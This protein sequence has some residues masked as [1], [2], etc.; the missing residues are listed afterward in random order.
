MVHEFKLPDV[1]DGAEEASVLKWMVEEGDGVREDDPIAEVETERAIIEIPSP[2]SGEVLELHAEERET[3]AVGATLVT[4]DTEEDGEENRDEGGVE[5]LDDDGNT[6]V[7][8]DAGGAV[9]H[10]GSDEYPEEG[11]TGAGFASPSTR[12][13]AREVGVDIEEVEGSGPEGRVVAQDVLRAAKEEQDEREEENGRG[14]AGTGAYAE[15]EAY[16]DSEDASHLTSEEGLTPTRETDEGLSSEFG[17]EKAPAVDPETVED[18]RM[19]GGEE[20]EDDMSSKAED[21]FADV[22]EEKEED[23]EEGDG[24][25]EVGETETTEVTETGEATAET[26]E[27]TDTTETMDATDTFEGVGEDATETVREDETE[28]QKAE[29]ASEDTETTDGVPYAGNRRRVGE[30]LRRSAEAPLVTHHD[31]ADA[32]RLVEVRE[33]LRDDVEARLTYT[34][35]F[36][37]ACGVALEDYEV[38]NSRIDEEEEMIRL[39]EDV[40]VGVATDTEDGLRFPVVENV[41]KKGVA[42][43]AADLE[44]G[45]ERPREDENSPDGTED[46]TFTIYNVGAIGGE[47]TTPLPNHPETAAVAIGEIRQRPFV[48]GGE[49][50]ARQTVP[51]SLTF[52][53]RAADSASAARFTNDLKR[54]LN[55]PMEMLL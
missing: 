41:V 17:Q 50:V 16:E 5:I 39:H 32:E 51:L 35:F 6:A 13:L 45:A 49:V 34:P 24:E 4:F 48:V 38:F 46:G 19:F 55:D 28:T 37:K 18:T 2:V 33:R 52:D 1:G 31:T 29:P 43:I 54:Y 11:E 8:V 14:V 36:I 27:A 20:D 23:E 47:G 42:E 15:P 21:M 22:G 53:H 30:R 25:E 12:L 10:E 26:T 40:N 44:D 9:E 7:E 3:V